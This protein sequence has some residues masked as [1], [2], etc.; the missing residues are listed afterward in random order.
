[1]Q[2][3][4]DA[5]VMIVAMV[6]PPL[7]LE[8]FEETVHGVP[9][10]HV[11]CLAIGSIRRH[12][13]GPTLPHAEPMLRCCSAVPGTEL[14]EADEREMAERRHRPALDEI[15]RR[16]ALGPALETRPRKL[17]PPA[18][19]LRDRLEHMLE[20]ACASR[21][22]APT[23]LTITSSPPGRSTRRNS[24]SAISGWGTVL[25]TYWATTTS[26]E[27]SAKLRFSA[28]ITSSRSTCSSPSSFTP[29]LPRHL[30]H[31]LGDIDADDTAPGGV[32]GQRDARADAHLQDASA[33]CS[34]APRPC[35]APLEDGPEDHVVDRRPAGVGLDHGVV[36]E[37]SCHAVSP[38]PVR[39]AKCGAPGAQ[40]R[41]NAEPLAGGL[42][43]RIAGGSML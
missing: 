18:Q 34:L 4:V 23:R 30:Q 10:C 14:A 43:H 3:L 42:L 40:P 26:K 39:C 12:V 16:R 15:G 6:V 36:A 13:R 19:P 33:D 11:H 1:M 38:S 37:F 7:S 5:A 35:G 29:A 32:V 24:S 25:T 2:R 22:S 17:G 21:P 41:H 9:H 28:S 20:R 8:L 27:L 31:R